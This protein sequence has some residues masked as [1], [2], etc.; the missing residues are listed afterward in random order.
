MGT[1][2]WET[3]Y[4]SRVGKYLE[5]L[6][7][8]YVSEIEKR[9][10]DVSDH[11]WRGREQAGKTAATFSS[12]AQSL[13]GSDCCKLCQMYSVGLVMCRVNHQIK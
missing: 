4:I 9:N 5:I 13:D 6:A 11:C 7:A 3:I 1:R 10:P 12:S 2:L 8:V